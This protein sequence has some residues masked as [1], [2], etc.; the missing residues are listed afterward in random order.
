MQDRVDDCT[1]IVRNGALPTRLMWT[2]Y[3]HQ[4]LAGLRY[5]MGTSS[6]PLQQLGKGLGYSDYYL[7]ISIRVVC[8]IK[9]SGGTFPL[10]STGLYYTTL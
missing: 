1:K 4:L 6:T 10:L 2:S 8:T 7:I 3:T 5:G 9:R